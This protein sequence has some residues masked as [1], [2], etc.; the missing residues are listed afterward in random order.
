MLEPGNS[1]ETG[2]KSCSTEGEA[3]TLVR[4]T[5]SRQRIPKRIVQPVVP[6]VKMIK[7]SPASSQIKTNSYTK[8]LLSQF[9]SD[10]AYASFN[11]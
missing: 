3:V 7:H 4:V 5:V 2:R 1:V 11:K 8:G 6:V 9:L 10:T